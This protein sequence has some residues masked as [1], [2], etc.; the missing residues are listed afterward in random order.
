MKNEFLKLLKDLEK[1][2]VKTEKTDEFKR[3]YNKDKQE[4]I[5]AKNGEITLSYYDKDKIHEISFLS[6]HGE[7]I[8]E[9]DIKTVDGKKKTVYSFSLGLPGN[10]LT[11]GVFVITKDGKAYKYGSKYINDLFAKK[12]KIFS[13]LTKEDKKEII[14]K[15]MILKREYE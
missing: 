7:I 15:T 14:E 12:K 8:E 6:E 5:R 4:I 13:M 9:R 11:D 1:E 3:C 10:K 2:T